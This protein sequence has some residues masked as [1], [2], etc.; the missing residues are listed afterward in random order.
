MLVA[1]DRT[2]WWDSLTAYGTHA[3]T[4]VDAP[5]TTWYLAEGATHSGFNLF[6]LVQNPTT[7]P[8][9]LQVSYLLPAPAAPVVKTYAVAA[10][11]RFNIWVN[12]EGAALAATDVSAVLTSTNNV[13]LIVERAMYLDS[14]GLAFGA[15]HE[16][17]G[18]RSPATEWYLAE[19]A[20]GPYFDLFVLVANPGTTDATIQA[21][22]LLPNGTTVTKAHTVR[23]QSRFNIWVD[24]QD[25]ALADTAVSTVIT[26]TNNVPI[27][28][29]RSMWWPGPQASMWQEAHNSAGATAAGTRWAVADGESGGPANVSTYVLIANPSAQAASVRVSLIFDSIVPLTVGYTIAPNSRFNVDF[30]REFNFGGVDRSYGVLV[31]SLGTN[32]MPIVVERAMYSDARGVTWAAGTNVL[33]TRLQ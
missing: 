17:L 25:P 12:R 20:T 16:S 13:P 14:G 18:V 15:G 1:V 24:L 30:R 22:Y 6:Y 31:E 10:N 21:R 26:S 19:G 11:S 7:T 4:A 32:P 2:M 29:E 8:A 28:V 23:A 5:A 9:S 33:A 27:I 3:E